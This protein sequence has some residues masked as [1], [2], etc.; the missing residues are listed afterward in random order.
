MRI[1][2]F[3]IVMQM[4]IN[5]VFA[6]NGAMGRFNQLAQKK[7]GREFTE[8]EKEWL[9]EKFLQ[10][11]K[12]VVTG[13]LAIRGGRSASTKITVAVLVDQLFRETEDFLLKK[14]DTLTASEMKEIK[15]ILLE[16]RK[17]EMRKLGQSIKSSIEAKLNA[18]KGGIKLTRRR[19][20][21]T[22]KSSR[23]D[24]YDPRP[25]QDR[26]P[27]RENSSPKMEI[28]VTFGET[29]IKSR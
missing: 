6:Q 22:S 9:K 15:E 14:E 27:K 4:S 1:L 12:I 13:I 21:S 10:V 2:I 5:S 7:E 23:N 25:Y 29:E 19:K 24:E 26:F 8:E 20:K 11:T 17:E 18:K 28:E 16:K 3:M